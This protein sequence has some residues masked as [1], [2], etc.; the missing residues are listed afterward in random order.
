MKETI[1]NLI[2]V[3]ADWITKELTGDMMPNHITPEVMH[4][5]AKLIEA[6]ECIKIK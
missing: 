3:V 4:S 5:L 1:D 2:E 6:R